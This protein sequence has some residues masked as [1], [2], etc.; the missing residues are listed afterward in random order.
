M[1]ED[2]SINCGSGSSTHNE[3]VGMLVS[4]NSRLKYLT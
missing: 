1:F 3:N 2:H 4:S